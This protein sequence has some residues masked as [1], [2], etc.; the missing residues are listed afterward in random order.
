[1]PSYV[2]R[3]GAVVLILDPWMFLAGRS[4]RISP[5]GEQTSLLVLSVI[6]AVWFAY[7]VLKTAFGESDRPLDVIVLYYTGLVS[8]FLGTFAFAYWHL[9]SANG[10]FGEALSK[11]DA[12]YF[13]ITTFTTTGFGDLH[14]E[15]DVC[16]GVVIAQMVVGFVIISIGI[17]T[18]IGRLQAKRRR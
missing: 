7:W 13:T 11:V 10:C 1:M 6:A 2:L 16:R 17:A 12:T 8:Q 5:S 9:G 4:E 15:G 3:L 14:V 18:A